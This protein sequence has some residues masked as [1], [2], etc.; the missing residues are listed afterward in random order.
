[1]KKNILLGIALFLC[2]LAQA[3]FGGGNTAPMSALNSGEI[4]ALDNVKKV[5]II[6]DYSDLGVGAF[7]K[8]QDYVDQ[9][10]KALEEKEKGKGDKFK[11]DWVGA[12]S[13]VFEPHF[14]E[15]FNK[16]ADDIQMTGKNYATDNDYTLSVHTVF[17]EPGTNVGIYKKPAFID[18]ECV[19]KDKEGKALCT[20]YIKNAIGS[21]VMG[22][23]YAV[24]SRLK[25]S[26]GKAAKM[27]IGVIEKERKKAAKKK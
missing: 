25:E 20:F 9:K 2:V 14:E 24:S 5:N 19:F 21:Q 1:M 7:R 26:F 23:D 16:Y 8:E 22:F 10:Y 27:L 15:L 17:I 11:E 3:Q 4:S 12:R 6:Y 18:M 13:K